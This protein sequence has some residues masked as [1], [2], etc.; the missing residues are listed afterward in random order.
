MASRSFHAL[1]LRASD[2]L[3]G[4]SRWI[5]LA[6]LALAIV[7]AAV[8]TP[9][10]ESSRLET[11]T[12][13]EIDRLAEVE[14]GL[15]EMRSA[16]QAV[17]QEIPQAASV[18]LDRL[19]ED[20][21]NDLDRLTATRHRIAAQAAAEALASTGQDGAEPVAAQPTE[22][23][24]RLSTDQAPPLEL[25]RA[26]WVADLRDATGRD[27]TLAAL[28]PIVDQLIALPR[29]FDI[30]QSWKNDIQPRL[31]ARLDAAASAMP[32]LRGRFSEAR[33]PWDTF[34][35]ALSALTRTARDVRFAAPAEPFWWTVPAD[36]E[37]VELGLSPA[38]RDAIRRPPALTELE[39]KMDGTLE[40]FGLLSDELSATRRKLG[41]VTGTGSLAGAAI[42]SAVPMFPLLAGLLLSGVV[43]WRSQRLRQLGLATQLAIEH[44]G[45]PALRQWLWSQ[46]QWGPAHTSAAGAWRASVLQILVGYF[47]AMGWITLA[48]VQLRQLQTVDRTQLMTF[49][50][51]GASAI[52]IAVVHR[53]LVTR[54]CVTALDTAFEIADDGDADH[55]NEVTS[56][57]QLEA[58]LIDGR[59]LRR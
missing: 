23:P 30:E 57:E 6:V 19:A 58:E 5:Y 42:A 18:L 3:A 10:V 25:D 53:L 50:I 11:E 43:I 26:E 13:S 21:A 45:P 52:L 28:A 22:S 37:Q 55:L 24:G 29:Y 20:L 46:V 33:E 44:G 15:G 32:R 1:F 16:L 41:D 54:R 51:A 47:L 31:E 27:E 14:R 9:F 17:R 4:T 34:A 49:T 36:E 48:A 38:T 59:T 7:H 2:Q 40:S 12:I 8:L 39:A 56:A 35:G